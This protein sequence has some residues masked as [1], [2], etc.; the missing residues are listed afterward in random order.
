MI[1]P[2]IGKNSNIHQQM[3]G[4]TKI[5]CVLIV[6]YDLAI[7]KKEVQMSQFG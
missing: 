4:E 7:E 1:H 2:S 3:N 5:R 6:E